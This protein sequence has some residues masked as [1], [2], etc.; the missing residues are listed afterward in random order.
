MVA[1]AVHDLVTLTP[2]LARLTGQDLLPM[3]LPTPDLTPPPPEDPFDLL[4]ELDAVA[5]DTPHADDIPGPPVE[6]DETRERNLLAAFDGY[7]DREL[8]DV[9]LKLT[10]DA[11][12][13]YANSAARHGAYRLSE[14]IARVRRARAEAQSPADRFRP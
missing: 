4:D 12:E 3:T 6:D 8:H 10:I 11:E 7:T 9:V 2:R 5:A 14:M 1:R 13:Y